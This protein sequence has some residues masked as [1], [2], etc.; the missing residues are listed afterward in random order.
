MDTVAA[1]MSGN[2]RCI[3]RGPI[4][5][6]CANAASERRKAQKYRILSERGESLCR[7]RSATNKSA[8]LRF[9]YFRRYLSFFLAVILGRLG[10]SY[11]GIGILL[12]FEMKTSAQRTKA[13][14]ELEN[15]SD[16]SLLRRISSG[17]D[18]AATELYLR[19]ANHSERL[20]S[21][22][23]RQRSGCA[24]MR[25]TWSSPCSVHFFAARPKG[26]MT[27]RQ[28]ISSGSYL[29][30][31]CTQQ[32]SETRCIPPGAIERDVTKTIG[33]AANHEMTGASHEAV[34]TVIARINNGHRRAPLRFAARTT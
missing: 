28:G 18:D 3:I 2:A 20:R 9:L 1:T 23:Q 22:K 6:K 5:I 16:R 15:A 12:A 27:F 24:S 33:S 8:R 14:G 11:C 17:Q 31:D 13:V 29:F 34:R 10:F 4:K 30:R 26:Y 25:R 7:E 21:R 32:S 19:Y